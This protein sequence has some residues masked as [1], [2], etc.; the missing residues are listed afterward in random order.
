[1]FPAPNFAKF[2]ANLVPASLLSLSLSLNRS[3]KKKKRENKG[4]EKNLHVA[5]PNIDVNLGCSKVRKDRS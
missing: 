4:K 3:K 5:L 2:V 1:M